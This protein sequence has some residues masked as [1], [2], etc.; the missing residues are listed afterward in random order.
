MAAMKVQT[1]GGLD[2]WHPRLPFGG[3]AERQ[4]G[5]WAGGQTD[6]GQPCAFVGVCAAYTIVKEVQM[7]DAIGRGGPQ[8]EEK[9]DLRPWPRRSSS[10]RPPCCWA[11]RCSCRSRFPVDSRTQGSRP[12]RGCAPWR[13][14]AGHYAPATCKVHVVTKKVIQSKNQKLISCGYCEIKAPSTKGSRSWLFLI[15][16]ESNLVTPSQPVRLYQGKIKGEELTAQKQSLINTVSS[17]IKTAWHNATAWRVTITAYR[18]WFSPAFSTSILQQKLLV[19][20]LCSVGL[21]SVIF[22]QGCLCLASEIRRSAKNSLNQTK[23][24]GSNKQTNKRE[25]ERETERQRERLTDWL[26]DWLID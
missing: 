12:S 9:T 5:N 24:K 3:V 23:L 17:V 25:R 7:K 16:A 11:R 8:V 2:I 10:S 18:Y 15:K 20:F 14:R 19:V 4:T 1:G 13:A 26:I 21:K 6:R 22:R